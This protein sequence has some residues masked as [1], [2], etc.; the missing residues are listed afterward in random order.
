M[1]I[2][3]LLQNPLDMMDAS[4]VQDQ[5]RKIAENL[6][7]HCYIKCGA[8]K[9]YFAEIEFYYYDKNEEKGLNKEWNEKTYP[10]DKK[11]VG[12]LFFHYSGVDICFYSSFGDGKF[13]GILIR[14]LKDGKSKQYITGPTV[15][16]LEILNECSK[17]M[18]RLELLKEN[19]KYTDYDLCKEPITRYGI[20]YKTKEK[21]DEPLCF[22][23]KNLY[24]KYTDKANHK[25]KFENA[26][27]DYSKKKDGSVKGI[28]VLNRYYHRFDEN[29]GYKK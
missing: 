17:E 3:E 4:N 25:E 12:E 9:Y 7:H 20:T 18:P 29:G 26:R 21:E 5:F 11:E 19:E 22:F 28:S 1:T 10:R 24:E 2:R 23:D 13:G 16:M 15:C 6:F 14:S 8:K 27:W